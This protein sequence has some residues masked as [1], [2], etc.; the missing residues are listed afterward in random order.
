MEENLELKSGKY[1]EV[2]HKTCGRYRPFNFDKVAASSNTNLKRSL[3]IC[4]IS[5]DD[6]SSSPYIQLRSS[7]I[8][9]Y[10]ASLP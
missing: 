8:K 6:S 5:K 9:L 10:M 2:Y 3:A 4:S 1:I 7:W